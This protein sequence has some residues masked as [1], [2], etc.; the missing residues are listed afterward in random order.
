MYNRD[1]H[2][3]PIKEQYDDEEYENFDKNSYFDSSLDD[4][5]RYLG[6]PDIKN[7]SLASWYQPGDELRTEKKKKIKKSKK[8][9]EPTELSTQV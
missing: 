5:D 7:S 8:R 3:I 2:G 9:A 1:S 4:H 6:E